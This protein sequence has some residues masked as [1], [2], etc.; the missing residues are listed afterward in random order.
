MNSYATTVPRRTTFRRSLFLLLLLILTCRAAGPAQANGVNMFV[1]NGQVVTGTVTTTGIDTYTFTVP[2]NGSIFVSAGQV[3]TLTSDHTI[4]LYDHAGTQV[5]INTG[6]HPQGTIAYSSTAIGGTWTVKVSVSNMAAGG[7]YSLTIWTTPG[8][9]SLSGNNMGGVAYPGVSYPLSIYRGDVDIFTFNVT[10]PGVSNYVILA[11]TDPGWAP[12]YRF[13]RP[14]GTFLINGSGPTA[15]VHIFVTTQTGIYTLLVSRGAGGTDNPL[16]YTLSLSQG[17]GNPM[18]LPTDCQADGAFCLDCIDKQALANAE[19]LPNTWGGSSVADP[20]NV[21]TGNLYET[22][23]DYSTAGQNALALTRYY[24]SVSYQR[25]LYPTLIGL[26]WRTNYDR[27][28]RLTSTVLVAAER[29]DGQA[30]NFHCNVTSHVCT[31]DN[32]NFDYS[33]SSSGTTWTLTDSDDTVETYTAAAG[34]GTLNSIKL[35]NGYTQTMNY[36]TG[37]LTSVSDSYS[38]SLGMT[39][40]SGLLTG[41]T[42]P[43]SLTLTYGYIAFASASLLQSVSYNTSPV[44]KQTYL[45]E[46][47][48]LPYAL[49]GITDENNKRFATWAYNSTGQVSSAQHALGADLTQIAYTSNAGNTVTGPLGIVNTYKF[50]NRFSTPQVKEIDRAANG[51]VASATSS[52]AYDSNGYRNS[53][54]DWNGNNTSWVNNSHGMPTQISYSSNTSDKQITNITYDFWFPR[55]P[56]TIATNG[57]TSNFAYDSS[58]NQLTR[59]DRDLTSQ[60][61]PYVTNGQTRTW[62]HTWNTTG[63]MLTEQ[64]PRTDVTAKT[65]YGYT[66][67][68]L[69][70]ITDALSHVTTIAT[71]QGG[72]LPKKVYDPNGIRTTYTWTTRNWLSSSVIATSAGNLTTSY[73]FDSA[74]NLTK[75]TLPDNS[76]LSYGYDNAHRVTS[77]TN[78][79]GE[80]QGITY[81]SASLMTQTLWKNSSGVTK[82]QHTAT[83]DALGEKLTDVGGM[84]QS[85]SFTYDKNSNTLTVTDPLS[86]VTTNTWDSLNRLSTTKN[87]VQDLSSIKYDSHSRPLTVTDGRNNG[88]SYVYNGFGDTIQQNSPDSLKTIYF[89]DPDRNVIGVNQSGINFSSATYDALDRLLTRTYSGDSTLNV[90]LTYDQAAHGF[91]IGHLTSGTDAT[92]SLSRN[93]DERGNMTTDARTISSQLYSTGY[94]YESAGRLSSITYASSGWLVTYTRDSAGQIT[95]VTTTQPLHTAVNLA[96]SVTHMPFGPVASLTWGNGVTDARTFDLDYRMTSITDHGTA[97]IQYLSYSYNAGNNPTTI[98][99]NVTGGNTQTLTYDQIDRLKSATGAYGTVSSITYDSNSNRKTYGAI[100]YTTPGANDRMSTA[101]GSAVTYISTGNVNGIGTNTMTYNQANQLKTAVVSGTTSTYTYDFLGVRNKIKTGTSPFQIT[102][103]DQWGNLLTETSQAATP[104][105][106]DYA[107]MD[108]MPIAAIQ[109][110]AAT[111]SALHTD[112][113]G[114]VLR[115]TDST[116]TIVYTANFNPNGGVTPTTTITMLLRL[117]GQHADSTGLY[118]N[119]YRYL[120]PVTLARFGQVDLLGLGARMNP[121]IYG[122]NNPFKYIDPLGLQEI[123]EGPLGPGELPTGTTPTGTTPT[124]V[125]PT[126]TAPTTPPAAPEPLPGQSGG[127]PLPED[128]SDLTKQGYQETSDPRAAAAG[129]RTFRNPDTG[130]E[131]RYDCPKPGENGYKEEGHYHRT[132]PDSTGDKDKYL[133]KE[134][135]PAPRGSNQSH[136][137]PGNEA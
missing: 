110:T 92:G 18:G 15:G 76:Y 123:I 1:G 58:G 66:G 2:N 46:N 80:S 51:T 119:I 107:Y 36:T 106:T 32:P 48:A 113:L 93:W 68:T 89:Y 53:L 121:Y 43:D 10:H 45:Y 75:T 99:D 70:S 61:V 59:T 42:T 17:T 69:T 8:P 23:T 114:T 72:G 118:Y 77:I 49:T 7:S 14:D 6:V 111:I 62:T 135:N 91:G 71:A 44:T 19:A 134:G 136:L 132:N 129:H 35:R 33:L 104:V 30:I 100:S 55:L 12:A 21:A 88:T 117:L 128:P 52:I 56:H 82:R 131:L 126:E 16:S 67:G 29:P 38:R 5:A 54:T 11:L 20:I 85:T 95:A 37:V 116:K 127:P 4:T 83:F 47:T 133:D 50:L 105:E 102:Q 94:T 108:G 78:I 39:Y 25:S 90:S 120:D 22:Y 26:N 41:V 3:G 64:L 27:Y 125:T 24:N 63:Q 98:T 40:T 101:N 124:K 97:N 112:N 60:S 79:L 84:S 57:L 122:L 9:Y 13:Y 103:Y 28:L 87:A 73:N 137:G 130:D 74:G 86:H 31:P 115:G 81:N 34:K 65:T 109:P 96:T